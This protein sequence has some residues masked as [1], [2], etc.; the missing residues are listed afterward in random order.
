MKR[1]MD[2]V[3]NVMLALEANGGAFM[4]TMNTAAL[5]DT[6]HGQEAVEYLLML[7]SASFLESSQRS[8]YRIQRPVNGRLWVMSVIGSALLEIVCASSMGCRRT[9]LSGESSWGR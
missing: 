9:L 8:V 3:R 7:H 1:D 5:G 2:K 6:D 4:L